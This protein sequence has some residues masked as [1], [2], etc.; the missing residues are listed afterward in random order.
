MPRT[1]PPQAAPR[2]D[3]IDRLVEE[4]REAARLADRLV[5][6][7]GKAPEEKRGRLVIELLRTAIFRQLRRAEAEERETEPAELVALARAIKELEAAEKMGIER[8]LRIRREVA[9]EAAGLAAAAARKQGL[10]A[11]AAERIRARILGVAA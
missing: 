3:P 8:E 5:A 9:Q 10:S 4:M 7:L 1:T 2:A 11:E 6:D